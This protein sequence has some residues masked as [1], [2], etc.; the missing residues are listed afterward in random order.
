VCG[1]PLSPL[2]KSKTHPAQFQEESKKKKRHIM[3][4]GQ[5]LCKRYGRWK[6]MYIIVYL[7]IYRAIEGIVVDEGIMGKYF[8]NT[9]NLNG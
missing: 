9:Q 6:T 7:T 4:T 1:S 5:V 3:E 2:R 8:S